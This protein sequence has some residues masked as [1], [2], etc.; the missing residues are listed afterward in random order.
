LIC[1]AA[2]EVDHEAVRSLL[3][4]RC[5]ISASNLQPSELGSPQRRREAD[6]DQSPITSAG[7]GIGQ[8]RHGTPEI[9]R[10]QRPLLH[11]RLAVRS[12]DAP[13]RIAADE[14]SSSSPATACC[15]R[16]A[17]KRRCNVTTFNVV[18]WSIR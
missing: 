3:D 5:T 12:L 6:E 7:W 17:A 8:R 18:A 4:P 15:S 9:H 11:R 2:R 1:L 16:I 13:P 14:V 10:H